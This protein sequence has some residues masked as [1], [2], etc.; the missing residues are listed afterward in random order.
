MDI[1]KIIEEYENKNADAK[2][3]NMVVCLFNDLLSDLQELSEQNTTHEA[4]QKQVEAGQRVLTDVLSQLKE[5]NTDKFIIN[6]WYLTSDGYSVKFVTPIEKDGTYNV[7]RHNKENEYK[8][9]NTDK[10]GKTAYGEHIVKEQNTD[11]KMQEIIDIC[12]EI[13]EKDCPS[14]YDDLLNRIVA[15]AEEPSQNTDTEILDWIDAQKRLHIRVMDGDFS[16][17]LEL[18][19]GRYISDKHHYSTNIRDLITKAIKEA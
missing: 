13:P 3:A 7:F 19:T 16:R 4:L 17:E 15:I 1:Q 6:K 8:P 10:Q 18:T 5:Q 11:K 9:F 12:N 14:I 2:D